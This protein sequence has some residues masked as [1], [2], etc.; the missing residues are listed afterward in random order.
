MGS[1]HDMGMTRV[2][3]MFKNIK[4]M[5]LWHWNTVIT[6]SGCP[7][8]QLLASVNLPKNAI[9]GANWP[10]YMLSINILR[11]KMMMPYCQ[12]R[13]FRVLWG[14]AKPRNAARKHFA[15]DLGTLWIFSKIIDFH[16]FQHH[17]WTGVDYLWT[18]GRYGLLRLWEPKGC[19]EVAP[20]QIWKP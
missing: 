10:K 5:H 3:K 7:I 12:K 15:L 8:G 17:E 18:H 13:L 16:Y 1:I 20:D 19:L 4:R 6:I 9:L 2:W 11:M 14:H